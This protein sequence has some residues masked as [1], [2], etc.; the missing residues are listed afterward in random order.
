MLTN[1]DDKLHA[2]FTEMHIAKDDRLKQKENLEQLE[3]QFNRSTELIPIKLF[4]VLWILIAFIAVLLVNAINTNVMLKE[5]DRILWRMSLQENYLD[6]FTDGHSVA[7]VIVKMSNFTKKRNNKKYWYSSPFLTFEGG[8]QMRLKVNAFGDGYHVKVALQL[9]KDPYDNELERRGDFPLK[10][11]ATVEL[12][13]Q[14]IN[15]NHILV[16]IMLDSISCSDCAQRVKGNPYP[17]GFS[18]PLISHSAII[19]QGAGY[20]HKDQLVFRVSIMEQNLVFHYYYYY[21]FMGYIHVERKSILYLSAFVVLF[22]MFFFMSWHEKRDKEWFHR[23]QYGHMFG[24]YGRYILE[25]FH[26][27][28]AHFSIFTFLFLLTAFVFIVTIIATH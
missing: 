4:T 20:L 15:H 8:H 21:Y 16:P 23:L 27:F 12:L 25:S 7:P 26:R 2:V 5:S 19:N 17:R 22:S 14:F 3:Q 9:L 28:D 10:L 1:R 6:A 18:S 13:N 11:L 24:I